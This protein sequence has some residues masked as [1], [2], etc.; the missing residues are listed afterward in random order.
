MCTHAE[1]AVIGAEWY[2]DILMCVYSYSCCMIH[3]LQD[4]GANVIK[5]QETN[6][7]LILR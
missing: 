3:N 7:P 2:G 1:N 5:S 6:Q 4:K